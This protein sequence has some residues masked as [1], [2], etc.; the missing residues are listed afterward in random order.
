MLQYTHT[1]SSSQGIGGGSKNGGKG[2][3]NLLPGPLP[4]P[5][6]QPGPPGPRGPEGVF[7]IYV[8]VA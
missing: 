3:I 8:S 7:G 5:V 2:P 1:Q 6:G 4:I